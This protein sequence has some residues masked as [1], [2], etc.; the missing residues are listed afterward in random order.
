MSFL[1]KG[2]TGSHVALAE[3]TSELQFVHLVFILGLRFQ[4]RR[5][6]G[7]TQKSIPLVA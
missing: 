5:C 3:V 7:H 6:P 4:F 2:Q 1:I